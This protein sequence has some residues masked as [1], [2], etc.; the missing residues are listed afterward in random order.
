MKTKGFEF[1]L[2]YND[3]EGDFKW[4]ALLNMGTS[5]N[6]TLD[7]GENEFI[8]GAGF[9]NENISRTAV[10]HPAFQF[11]GWQFD[12][13]F[14]TQEEVNNYAGG[15]QASNLNAEPGD[16]RIV[17]ANG[18]GVIN[19]D[20]RTFIGNP[21]PK[22][23]YGLNLT[24][25]YK[26]FDFDLFFNGLAGVDVYNTNIYDLEGMP[27]LFNSGVGVLNRWTGPGTS[28]IVPRA[29]G[30]PSNTQVSSRF[31]ENGSFARL[32]NISIGYDL[33]STINMLNGKVSKFR[34][35]ISAQ[36]LFTI[37]DYSG[38]DPEVGQYTGAQAGTPPTA[39]GGVATN[40]N[41]QP[42]V[43]FQTGIDLG[44]YP[45]PKSFV[46]GVQIQF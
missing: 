30:A 27:R 46:G 33:T 17:D 42:N 35:Y 12:G 8:D 21:F 34:V 44:N 5:K 13:I 43:N 6:E 39:L 26:G 19:A 38:L 36:N 18:D 24:A 14:Q 2:G 40:A 28:N 22:L 16:F 4:S 29:G 31:V 37:T 20:D 15:T 11:Y 23:T 45:V 25:T 7:L 10:G 3:Y 9:E 41:G 32:R 1:T